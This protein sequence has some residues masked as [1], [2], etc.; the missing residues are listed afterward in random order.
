MN[1]TSN[2]NPDKVVEKIL[3]NEMG[4]LLLEAD[5][6]SVY[7]LLA[8]RTTDEDRLGMFGNGIHITYHLFPLLY[9]N[10]NINTQNLTK[11]RSTALHN[12]FIRW[13]ELGYNKHHAKNPFSCKAFINYLEEI[14][15]HQ[16][17]Y[18]LLMVE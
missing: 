5:E 6:S 3:E 16:A 10:K 18:M 13:D 4:I 7:D 12:V 9:K 2:I 14:E 8:E 11:S 1:T 15:F 17:D